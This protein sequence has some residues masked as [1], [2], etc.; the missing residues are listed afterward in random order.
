MKKN[1]KF[2][3]MAMATLAMIACGGKNDPKDP[4]DE[5]EDEPEYV[6]PITIDGTA[7][8]WDALGEKVAVAVC[9]PD[10]EK[11]ALKTLKVYADEVYV[12]VFAEFDPTLIDINE[13]LSNEEFPEKWGVPFHMYFTAGAANEGYLGQWSTPAQILTEG[14][15]F[16]AGQPTNYNPSI[17]SWDNPGVADNGWTWAE[18][19]AAGVVNASQITGTTV[20]LSVV[21]DLL[22]V[23][24]GNEFYFGADIQQAWDSQGILPNMEANEE[25]SMAAMLSV[26]VY[27][28]EYK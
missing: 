18:A 10:A 6:A 25:G 23:Q 20:E 14:F 22:P 4:K 7:A 28:A 27:E 13:D 17:F 8:E 3:L 26:K 15:L 2:A 12:Y 21:R 9:N 16:L 19:N 24:L 1:F 5:E 11:K